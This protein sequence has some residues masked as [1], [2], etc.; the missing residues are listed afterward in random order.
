MPVL[1]EGAHGGLGSREQREA[2]VDA[3][4]QRAGVLVVLPLGLCFLPAFVL[5]GVV[6]ILLG[7]LDD[8]RRVPDHAG[9]EV[10]KGVMMLAVLLTVI[11]GADYVMQAFRLRAEAGRPDPGPLQPPV[12]GPGNRP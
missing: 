9:H 1:G 5:V 11:S 10:A 12:P 3:A 4:A 7:V 2:R 6:P 8:V